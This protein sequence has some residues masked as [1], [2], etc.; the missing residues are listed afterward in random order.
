[1]MTLG[2]IFAS[3]IGGLLLDTSTPKFTLLVG[4]IVSAVGTL[5]MLGA[6]Q[7]TEK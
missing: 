7:P 5:I 3:Y 2:S 6:I 4:V 1:M